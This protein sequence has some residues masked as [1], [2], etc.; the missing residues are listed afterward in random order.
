MKITQICNVRSVSAV[1]PAPAHDLGNTDFITDD[2][3]N[4]SEASNPQSVQFR[5]DIVQ[6]LYIRSRTSFSRICLQLFE[7]GSDPLTSPLL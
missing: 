1:V 7:I 5:S 2:H 4:D 6:L 3:I